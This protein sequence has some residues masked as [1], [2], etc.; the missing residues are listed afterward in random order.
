MTKLTGTDWEMI[1]AFADG[2]IAASEK[3]SIARRLTHDDSLTA[4]LAEIQATKAALSL[5]RPAEQLITP[6]AAGSPRIRRLAIAASLAAAVAL[7]AVY[8]FGS[9]GEDWRDVPAELHAAF[10]G[11]AYVLSQG[12]T[13]PVISTARIGDVRAFDLS[14]SR[15]TLVDIQTTRLSARDVVAMHYRGR[16]GCRLTVVALETAEG[17]PAI[18]PARHDG[19]GARWSTGG[20][21]FYVLASGMDGDRFDAIAAYARAESVRLS[22]GDDLRLAL[23]SATDQAQP[24]A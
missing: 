16:N 20:I 14:S 9:L 17:D 22:R 6:A 12:A 24:C 19:L 7:G 8:Q 3:E 1:N 11:N 2:E 21:H 23:R 5:I 18:L 4:A 10:S 13:L 15:L